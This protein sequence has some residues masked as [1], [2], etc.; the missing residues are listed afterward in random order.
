MAE[1]GPWDLIEEADGRKLGATVIAVVISYVLAIGQG[2]NSMINTAFDL[3]VDPLGAVIDGATGFVNEL[4]G[5]WQDILR[6]GAKTAVASIEPGATWAVGPFTQA[7]SL[8]S[9][10]VSLYILAKVM[11]SPFT[12]NLVPGT[13][14]DNRL[15]SWISTTPEEED[16]D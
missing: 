3:F 16:E 9:V 1:Q 13:L 7:L 2:V 4:W 12:S 8:I 15:I 6:Q 14:V 11:A 10:V 5:G